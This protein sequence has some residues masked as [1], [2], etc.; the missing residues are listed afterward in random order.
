[1]LIG[2]TDQP[3][4]NYGSVINIEPPDDVK[5]TSVPDIIINPGGSSDTTAF[6]V[7]L[8]AFDMMQQNSRLKKVLSAVLKK[9]ILTAESAPVALAA[10]DTLDR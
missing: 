4:S 2:H 8:R 6:M 5:F 9:E 7:S 10:L 1:M 3:Q